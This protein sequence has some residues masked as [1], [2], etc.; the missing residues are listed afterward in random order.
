MSE[1]DIFE[2]ED[3]TTASPLEKFIAALEDQI[4]EWG[5]ETSSKSHISVFQKCHFWTWYSDTITR[6]S[7]LDKNALAQTNW[8]KKSKK[9]DFLGKS[10]DLEYHAALIEEKDGAGFEMAEEDLED[11][12]NKR[13]PNVAKRTKRID[14]QFKSLGQ[15]LFWSLSLTPRLVH[16]F[17]FD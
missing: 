10:F 11:K 7:P 9:L 5:L 12:R 2:I 3:Y 17:N 1:S 4:R 6:G 16:H 8:T 15:G 13:K 14:H